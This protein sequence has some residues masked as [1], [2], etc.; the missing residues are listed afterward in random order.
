MIAR[1]MAARREVGELKLAIL[2]GQAIAVV[3]CRRNLPIELLNLVLKEASPAERE[4]LLQEGG[5]DP[6]SLQAA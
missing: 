6:L 4:H 1:R 5:L 3:A 2:T